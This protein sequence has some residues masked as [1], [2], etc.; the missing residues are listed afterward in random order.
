M[1]WR[2]SIRNV[3]P[4][5]SF[6]PGQGEPGVI[7]PALPPASWYR[8]L[9]PT[10]FDTPVEKNYL[11]RWRLPQTLRL[12]RLSG[13]TAALMYIS[14]LTADALIGHRIADPLL[15]WSFALI[16]LTMAAL[17]GYA[18]YHPKLI[19]RAYAVAFGTLLVNGCALIAITALTQK[20]GNP[21]PLTWTL[22]LLIYA[23]IATGL[24]YR[25]AVP[26]GIGL[27]TVDLV[28]AFV[29]HLPARELTDHVLLVA[30]TVVTGIIACSALER[31]DRLGFVRA[32]QMLAHSYT[33]DLTGLH[34][35]RYLFEEG[36]RRIRHARREDKP[37]AVMMIDVDYFKRYN[38]ALGHPAGD[39]CL[40]E[41]SSS[42]RKAGRRPLDIVVRLGGEEFA[43][44]LFGCDTAAALQCA[45]G[46]R[47]RLA[48]RA[49]PH[50]AS[51]LQRLTVSI[52]IAA[53]ETFDGTGME[54]DALMLAA[55]K[56]LYRAKNA[57]RDSVSV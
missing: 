48:E 57:G 55:D 14:A 46:L 32:Q 5:E 50:P 4:S 41:V 27:G 42:F 40:R 20:A 38:D 9:L 30:A 31:S 36:G 15:F 6:V 2:T 49:I 34:N 21:F 1:H 43:M 12:Q 44:L 17:L 7:V 11:Y 28:V 10:R 45:E 24:P 8:W 23:F 18:T 22:L 25:V 52:G 16:S 39:Q 29:E 47:T 13:W 35:R 54:L 3:L 37:I 56:A 26:L 19:P 53:S 51:P 33:D